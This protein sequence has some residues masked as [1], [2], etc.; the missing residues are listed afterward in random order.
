MTKTILDIAQL[1]SELAEKGAVTDPAEWKLEV[2]GDMVLVDGNV[3]ALINLAELSLRLA[4][5][6]DVHSHYHIADS[7]WPEQ[8]SV[9][10]VLGRH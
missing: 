3:V 7:G 2:D 5:S 4:A 6:T 1:L 9:E 8:S 10:L